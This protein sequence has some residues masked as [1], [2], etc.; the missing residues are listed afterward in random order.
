M[1]KVSIKEE[2][3]PSGDYLA[4][5]QIKDQDVRGASFGNGGIFTASNGYKLESAA[6]PAIKEDTK[7]L[8][9]RGTDVSNDGI[10]LYTLDKVFINNIIVAIKE[11]NTQSAP[12]GDYA[13]WT[14]VYI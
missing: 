11:Y 8:F 6:R 5:L 7:K 9:V 3:T 2:T 14:E 12:R 1:L 10:I 13:Q 4:L